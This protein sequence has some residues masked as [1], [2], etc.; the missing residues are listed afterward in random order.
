MSAVTDLKW[1][2]AGEEGR[3]DDCGDHTSTGFGW[4]DD[5]D[6]ETGPS[7]GFTWLCVTCDEAERDKAE[8]YEAGYEE[9]M[10]R[11]GGN[12]P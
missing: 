9:F 6:V 5:G 12:H 4:Y 1:G 2:P 3:C 11:S 8:R 10:L 7:G